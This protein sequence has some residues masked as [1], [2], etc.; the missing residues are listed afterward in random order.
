MIIVLAG[1]LTLEHRL[2]G[3]KLALLCIIDEEVADLA[4]VTIGQSLVRLILL[5]RSAI[6]LRRVLGWSHLQAVGTPA[7]RVLN[8]HLYRSV[9][10]IFIWPFALLL[11]LIQRLLQ[12]VCVIL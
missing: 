2:F 12:S 10:R 3:D 4:Y 8:L 6:Q 5:K 1:A 9:V 11:L 7:G